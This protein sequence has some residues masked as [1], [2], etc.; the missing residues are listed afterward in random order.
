MGSDEAN[1]RISVWKRNWK[2]SLRRMSSLIVDEA[3]MPGFQFDNVKRN[4]FLAKQA[5]MAFPKATKTG[6]TICGAVFK[7]GVVVGADTRATGGDIVANKNC[8]KIHPLAPNMVCCGAGTAADCDKVTEMI[9]SQLELLSLNSDRQQRVKTANRLFQQMLFRYQGHIGAYLILAG[10]DFEG[11]HLY[12]IHAHGSSSKVPYSAMG[13]GSLAAISILEEGWHADM[14]EE[15][16]KKLVRDA[17]VA[18]IINDM[19]S[20]STVDIAVLKP[21][22]VIDYLR[23]YEKIV[24]KGEPKGSYKFAKGTTAVL[25]TKVVEIEDVEVRSIP[26]ET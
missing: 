17:I 20:G 22:D 4:A 16:A 6:T 1:C 19:G 7:G 8:Q 3:P 5:N 24:S 10:V 15:A 26:M 2:L 18:G 25:S 13:S 12:T 21:N 14:E 11:S 23:P 9:S